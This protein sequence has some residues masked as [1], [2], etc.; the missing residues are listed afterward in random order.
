MK[1]SSKSIK[2]SIFR[3]KD[4]KFLVFLNYNKIHVFLY[5]RLITAQLWIDELL[6]SEYIIEVAWIA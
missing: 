6:F 2:F 3:T 4:I 1:V 5:L